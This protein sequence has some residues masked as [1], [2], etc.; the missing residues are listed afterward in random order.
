MKRPVIVVAFSLVF[1]SSALASDGLPGRHASPSIDAGIVLTL[2]KDGAFVADWWTQRPNDGKILGG[3]IVGHWSRIGSERVLRH[4]AKEKQ[5]ETRFE[6][7]GG[8]VTILKVVHP[9]EF[10]FVA[11]FGGEYSKEENRIK[12]QSRASG[13]AGA[14]FPRLVSRWSALMSRPLDGLAK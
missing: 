4:A 8:T 10:P 1:A 6:V 11:C 7:L 3:S 12:R 2:R 14:V 5:G 13:P 9:G